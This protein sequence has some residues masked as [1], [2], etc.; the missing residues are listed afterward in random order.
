MKVNFE[1]QTIEMSKNEAKQAGVYGSDLYN[2]LVDMQ[3]DFPELKIVIIKRKAKRSDAMKG[4]TFDYMESY[5]KKNG[6]AEQATDF[7][8]LRKACDVV[9]A[10]AVT[11]GEVKKWFLEQFPE[12]KE[13][14]QQI[15]RIL[16]GDVA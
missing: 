4:L 14:S 8:D 7:D 5:I 2:K 3:H 13:Y 16:Q 11:Y 6:T 9:G 12:I 15:N 1:N 10:K